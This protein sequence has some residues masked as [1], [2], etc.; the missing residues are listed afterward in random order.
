MITMFVRDFKSHNKSVSF[1][2]VVRLSLVYSSCKLLKT[3]SFMTVSYPFSIHTISQ[4]YKTHYTLSHSSI[5]IQHYLYG[6]LTSFSTTAT[7][8]WP[9]PFTFLCP[10]LS[11]H[12][13]LSISFYP[14]SGKNFP[15]LPI[16]AP[17][18]F[19][20]LL[21]IGKMSAMF[22]CACCCKQ[23]KYFWTQ[24]RSFKKKF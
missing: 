18:H 23:K 4:L 11:L 6:L 19:R 17:L 9:R 16:A 8:P 1:N 21:N 3:R 10:C 20:L 15:F 12:L 24:K 22:T 13:S 7:F 14:L 5:L 2:Q